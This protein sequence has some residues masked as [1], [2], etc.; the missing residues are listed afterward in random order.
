M[1]NSLFYL[2]DAFVLINTVYRLFYHHIVVVPNYDNTLC[3]WNISTEI[4]GSNRDVVL[5]YASEINKGLVLCYK[6][7]RSTGSLCRIILFLPEKT[8]LSNAE[9]KSIEHFQ[10]EVVFVKPIKIDGKF[11]PHMER[12]FHERDW[13]TK[14]IDVVDRILHTDSMDVF[15]QGD[16]FSDMRS[17]KLVFVVEPH[18]FRSCGWNLGWLQDCYGRRRSGPVTKSYIICSGSIGGSA[19]EYEK[20]LNLMIKQ[21]EW[22]SCYDDSKDQPILNYLV[23]Q[24][25]VTEANI[26]Y[27][28]TGCN[29]DFFT[30]QW[31]VLDKK[32]LFNEHKQ[33]VSLVNTVPSYIH[34]YNRF[35]E[36]TEL[37]YKSCKIAYGS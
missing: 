16:P 26:S 5:L 28:Y 37:L 20:L 23:W 36:L 34:Q 13:L 6:S 17:D 32:I 10:I 14:N 21:P 25:L 12:Y 9:K 11:V 2:V 31:C 29:D 8:V 22:T 24:G 33:I 18:Q 35:P 3:S 7:L 19:K 27:T 15:F 30:M 1:F 4:S